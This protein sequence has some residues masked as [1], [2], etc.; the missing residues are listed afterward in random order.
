MM[1][2]PRPP[3]TTIGGNLPPG[4]PMV[5]PYWKPFVAPYNANCKA[6]VLDLLLRLWQG[7]V[8]NTVCSHWALQS[9]LLDRMVQ[10]SCFNSGGRKITCNLAKTQVRITFFHYIPNTT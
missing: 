2:I 9:P 8:T 10:P 7:S 6:R 4:F 3:V 5:N 1:C